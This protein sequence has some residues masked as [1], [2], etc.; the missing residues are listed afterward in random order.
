[1]S[2]LYQTLIWSTVYVDLGLHV[3]S[4]FRRRAIEFLF[5]KNGCPI[6]IKIN[7]III[8][9]V[10]FS[11]EFSCQLFPLLK[12]TYSSLIR[13]Q[14]CGEVFGIKNLYFQMWVLSTILKVLMLLWDLQYSQRLSRPRRGWSLCFWLKWNDYKL[15]F[16]IIICENILMSFTV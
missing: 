1:M 14:G 15:F 13:P 5:W 16:S 4:L 7:L 8:V 3:W 2:V 12:I 10:S 6:V 11:L 9:N